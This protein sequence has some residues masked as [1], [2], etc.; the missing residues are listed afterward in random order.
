MQSPYDVL[1]VSPTARDE[2]IRKA[3]RRLAKKLHPDL[4]PGD[5]AAE[6]RFKQVTAAQDLLLDPEKRKR[7]DAGEIDASGAEQASRKYYKDFAN[8]ADA[9]RAYH[10]SSGFADFSS[11][12]GL[13]AEIL[14]RQAE[15]LA[16]APGADRLYRI[17][18]SFLQAVNGATERL[19]LPEGGALDVV[20]PPGI[21]DGQALRLRGKGM[22]SRGSGPPG[23]A[24]IEVSVQAHPLFV[25]E[26][27]NIRIELP[28]SL[29]EAVLG[30]RVR[31]PT[32]S[33]EVMLTIPKSANSGTILRLKGKGVARK[34]SPGDQLVAVKLVLPSKAD[35]ELEAFCK[36][37][38][39][40]PDDDPRGGMQA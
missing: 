34:S 14:R 23:D 38:T 25:R 7:F 33:G 12:D 28:I 16:S 36:N 13:F 11:A 20:I 6:A 29:K 37:W 35:A 18:I 3:F 4:N 15:Q 22:P 40:D 26:G 21:E 1:E 9:A 32:P 2:D 30:A 39:P 31:V 8:G 27:N 24:L 5:K 10:D 19:N 17:S